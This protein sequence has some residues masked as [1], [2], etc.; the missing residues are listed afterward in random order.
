MI[1]QYSGT[2][3][4]PLNGQ[5]TITHNKLNE[6]ERKQKFVPTSGYSKF[7]KEKYLHECEFKVRQIKEKIAYQE[8]MFG[9]VEPLTLMELQTAIAQYNRALKQL[10]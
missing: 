9:D 10:N 3:F 7:L 4:R 8:Q 5:Y 6:V 1:E 2:K